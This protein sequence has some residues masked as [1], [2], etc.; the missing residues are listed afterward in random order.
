MF[1]KQLIQGFG[2][3]TLKPPVIL[4]V[5]LWKPNKQ[6]NHSSFSPFIPTPVEVPI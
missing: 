5:F 3:G 2:W 1:Q 6:M 4:N